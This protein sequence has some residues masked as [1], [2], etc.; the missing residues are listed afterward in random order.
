M[1]KANSEVATETHTEG[2]VLRIKVRAGG[3]GDSLAPIQNGRLRVTVTQP[4]ERGKANRAVVKLLAKQ[5]DVRSSQLQIL[6]G[7]TS[8]E[9]RLLIRGAIAEEVDRRIE[10][11]LRELT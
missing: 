11:K 8:A 3:R 7:E 2:T 1:S 10:E 5:L 4:A 6:R 9:K